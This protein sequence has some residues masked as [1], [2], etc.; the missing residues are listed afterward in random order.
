MRNAKT[1]PVTEP[2]ELL[3]FLLENIKGKNRFAIKTYLSKRMIWV[4]NKMET[5]HNYKLEVGQE[6]H[7]IAQVVKSKSEMKGVKILFEDDLIVVVEKCTNLLS[8][9]T[10][11]DGE[12]TAYNQLSEY[13]K[14][15]DED[16]KI[17]VIHRL[18]KETSGVM[19]FAKNEE[20]K[21]W[22]QE[23]WHEIVLQRNYLAF[24]E[25]E[26]ENEEGEIKSYLKENKQ[27][28]VYSSKKDNG[29]QLAVSNYRVLKRHNG[30]SLLELA[31]ETG[32]KN[33]IRVH[34]QEIGHPVVGDKKYGATEDPIGRLGL[35]AWILCF[36]H[37]VSEKEMYFETS[38][39]SGFK[40]C[41]KIK[42]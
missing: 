30:F 6:V 22:F 16:N 24:V 5:L 31:I 32:R 37:P 33:Q 12:L 28:V 19:I 15:Q 10:G 7:V 20:V 40:R 41:F 34:M 17:F 1:Y 21:S 42:D 25:G 18:D 27:F 38:M 39:P 13:V 9:S 29:G 36:I 2:M 8:I 23:N 26:V 35:H 14:S 4:D 11:K 3:P